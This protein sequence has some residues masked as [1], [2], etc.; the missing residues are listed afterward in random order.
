MAMIA[1]GFVYGVIRKTLALG[2]LTS[3]IG[4]FLAS[5]EFAAAVV[6][7]TLVTAVN[8]RTVA[9]ATKRLLDPERD[10]KS[11][12]GWSLLLAGKMLVLIAVIWCLIA[13]VNVDVVGFAI[14]FSLFMP[15]IGWQIVVAKPEEEE[16]EEGKN[17]DG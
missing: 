13:Y 14:G 12:T 4:F 2:A 5:K 16:T 17:A 11:A 10:G 9:W 15:A 1:P 8:L 3:L 7:G 6:I